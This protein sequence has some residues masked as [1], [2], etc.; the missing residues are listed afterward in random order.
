[1]VKVE[2]KDLLLARVCHSYRA[3]PIKPCMLG[4]GYL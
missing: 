2:G 3:H 1:M 4:V